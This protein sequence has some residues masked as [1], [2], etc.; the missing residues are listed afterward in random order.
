MRIIQDPLAGS[1][2][3]SLAPSKGSSRCATMKSGSVSGKAINRIVCWWGSKSKTVSIRYPFSSGWGSPEATKQAR[4]HCSEKGGSFHAGKKD[5]VNSLLPTTSDAL[6]IHDAAHE[7]EN[8][9]LHEVALKLLAISN[10]PHIATAENEEK[11]E[12]NPVWDDTPSIIKVSDEVASITGDVLY[13]EDGKARIIA[14][15]AV[16]GEIGHLVPK[17]I[18]VVSADDDLESRARVPLYEM[19]LIKKEQPVT[20]YPDTQIDVGTFF[21]L[22]YFRKSGAYKF[23]AYAEPI[24]D[25]YRLLEVHKNGEEVTIFDL[26]GQEPSGL[27]D[28][29]DKFAELESPEVAVFACL[30]SGDDVWVYDLLYY[31][32]HEVLNVPLIQRLDILDEIDFADGLKLLDYAT[33]LEGASE[34]IDLS[35]GKYLVRYMFEIIDD[36]K[37][38]FWFCHNA[39]E[40]KVGQPLQPLSPCDEIEGGEIPEDCIAINPPDGVLTQVHRTA[41][42]VKIFVGEGARDRADEF[43]DI[44]DAAIKI[45]E[46]CIIECVLYCATLDGDI[47][48]DEDIFTTDMTENISQAVCYDMAYWKK[49][50]TQLPMSERTALLEDVLVD[51]ED[52]FLQ[53]AS[54]NVDKD[55]V[56][57]YWYEGVRPLDTSVNKLWHVLKPC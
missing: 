4:S 50:I 46:D 20:E 30:M 5:A 40:V 15:A 2:S 53:I 41:E 36:L 26:R 48:S 10:Q 28:L 43:P 23:P 6:R 54:T 7:L 52:E 32:D 8:D 12:H 55:L 18:A 19:Y 22:G 57:W 14:K 35:P 13:K 37:R 11:T 9:G 38:P 27:E 29:T 47:V 56:V 44:R 42:R 3:C 31:E 25:E 17:S 21:E 34:L 45:E 16:A 39:G 1:H 51:A 49:D 33:I 24:P